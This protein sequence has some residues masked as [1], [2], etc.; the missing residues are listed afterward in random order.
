MWGFTNLTDIDDDNTIPHV[1]FVNSGGLRYDMPSG[2]ITY[3]N[4]HTT[5]P[6]GNMNEVLMVGMLQL[7]NGAE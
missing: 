6:F 5:Q 7:Y 4:I 2:D 3:G 1:A